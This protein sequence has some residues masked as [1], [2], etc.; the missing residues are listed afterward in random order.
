M[1]PKGEIQAN[2]YY[3]R[4]EEQDRMKEQNKVKT[5]L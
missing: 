3:G 5:K 1:C 4:S 2:K